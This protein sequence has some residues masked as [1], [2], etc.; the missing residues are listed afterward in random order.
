MF[1]WMTKAPQWIAKVLYIVLEVGHE[2]R[3]STPQRWYYN[4]LVAPYGAYG[5]FI[6]KDGGAH[7]NT[8]ATKSRS[9]H[10]FFAGAAF[11]DAKANSRAFRNR[12]VKQIPVQ[13]SQSFHTFYKNCNNCS[14]DVIMFR[15]YLR[16]CSHVRPARIAGWM[17]NSI[18]C[19]QP[20]GD[21]ETRKS[22]Y[23]SIVSGC[24]P[25]FFELPYIPTRVTYPFDTKIDYSKFTVK[26]PA[27]K[28]ITEMLDPYRHDVDAVK[29]LQR[30]LA[31]VAKYLQYNDI[32]TPDV[33]GDAFHLLMDQVGEHF[34]F[35]DKSLL[36]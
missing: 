20:P 3:A 1:C 4:T 35:V 15:A 27:N 30:N 7:M 23:D 26:I 16:P 2:R 29:Q 36:F 33:D 9:I 10:I 12:V 24:I 25:V 18:F 6:Q 22:F 17:Q 28:T 13:T 5:H 19:L 11:V 31:R 8:M 32:S 14:D 34:G 21:S